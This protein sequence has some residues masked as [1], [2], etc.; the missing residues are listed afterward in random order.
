MA[1]SPLRRAVFHEAL[2]GFNSRCIGC[3]SIIRVVATWIVLDKE[4]LDFLDSLMFLD[5]RSIRDLNF[6]TSRLTTRYSI[7]R[8]KELIRFL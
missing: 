6:R 5:N 4:M 2:L 8:T 7:L 1:L 3:D